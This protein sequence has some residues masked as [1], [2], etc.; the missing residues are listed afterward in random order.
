M[1]DKP[2]IAYVHN[3][4]LEAIRDRISEIVF[5]QDEGGIT[6]RFRRGDESLYVPSPQ[7]KAQVVLFDCLKDM[8]GLSS[9]GEPGREDG[10]ISYTRGSEVLQLPVTLRR[11]PPVETIVISLSRGKADGG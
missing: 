5:R 8:A 9:D 11:A 7:R 6:L 4:I 1:F 2:I 3:V 10:E